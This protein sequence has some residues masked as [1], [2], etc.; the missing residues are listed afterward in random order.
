MEFVL[1]Q[2]IFNTP[3]HFKCSTDTMKFEKVYD[4][5][6]GILVLGDSSKES[7][8]VCLLYGFELPVFPS[9]PFRKQFEY[10]G[11]KKPIPWHLVLPTKI[12]KQEILK[13]INESLEFFKRIDLDYY[14][15]IFLP[16]EEIFYDLKPAKID[17]T[18]F[19]KHLYNFSDKQDKSHLKTFLPSND[20]AE[21]ASYSR[22]LS[23][24]GRLKHINGPRALHIQKQYRNIITSRF[25]DDGFISY[26]DYSS[27]E[28][29]TLLAINGKTDCPQDIY[30]H[31]VKE[32]NIAVPR[33]AIKTAILSRIYGASEHS[34][35]VQLQTL[36]E[37]PEDVIQ[38]V[39]EYFKINDLKE[40]LNESFAANNYKFIYN[41]YGRPIF[42][43]DVDSYKLLNYY[44]QSTAVDVAMLGFND[45]NRRIKR[46]GLTDKIL[47]IFIIHDAIIF[48]VHNDCKSLLPKIGKA[49]SVNIKGFEKTNFFL[50][51]ETF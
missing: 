41:F 2:N 8:D 12:Y 32:L 15:S 20:F 38:L 42:C 47:P 30:T 35:A 34:I 13:I 11:T 27:L 18:V 19:Y 45:I 43:P 6:N 48:D 16:T 29:R 46:A 39:D 5:D 17:T 50:K 25:G 23:V 40:Q 44:I 21:Q 24:T 51:N 9:A 37:Y 3:F 4:I 1:H 36:V 22:L 7:N 26:F 49:G 14:Q 28:P 33:Q 10:I 31:V